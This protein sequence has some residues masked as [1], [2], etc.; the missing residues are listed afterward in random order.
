[1]TSKEI[2]EWYMLGCSN[3]Q[4]KYFEQVLNDLE[5]KELLENELKLEKDK[6]KYVMN[7]LKMQ[8]KILEILEPYTRLEYDNVND[9]Y[10]LIIDA[11]ERI[12]L[13][14]D[15]DINR[16]ILGIDDYEV[17]P[18]KEWLEDYEKEK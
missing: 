13:S 6:V 8:D 14:E 4:K 1:M 5:Q 9:E 18:I 2:I 3:K 11:S 17:M 16:C 15:Y 7:Q 12:P 10:N